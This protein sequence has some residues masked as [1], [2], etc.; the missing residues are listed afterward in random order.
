MPRAELGSAGRCCTTEPVGIL[1]FIFMGDKTNDAAEFWASRTA[2][3]SAG[4]REEI[5]LKVKTGTAGHLWQVKAIH[6]TSLFSTQTGVY[7]FF[8]NKMLSEKK[9]SVVPKEKNCWQWA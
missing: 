3:I 9:F 1:P 4:L 8:S 5:K 6:S 7:S 2:V